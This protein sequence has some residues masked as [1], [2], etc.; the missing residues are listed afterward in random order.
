MLGSQLVLI[1]VSKCVQAIDRDCDGTLTEE[2]FIE[3][4]NKR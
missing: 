3:A 4:Y 1:Y 2:E